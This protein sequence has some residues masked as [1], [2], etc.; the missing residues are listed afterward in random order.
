MLPK[1][2]KFFKSNLWGSEC[3][4]FTTLAAAQ[5]GSSSPK[6]DYI[7]FVYETGILG[8]AES[9]ANPHGSCVIYRTDDED[10]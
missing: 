3:N 6:W 2:R 10:K 8:R 7:G 4:V 5:R 9:G 1:W